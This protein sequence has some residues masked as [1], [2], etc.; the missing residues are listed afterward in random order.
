MKK[1]FNLARMFRLREKLFLA[2]K[3]FIGTQIV[4]QTLR[5]LFEDGLKALPP[6][7]ASDAFFESV[8]ALAGQ[9]LTRQLAL[10]FAGRIAGNVGMLINSLPVFPWTRQIRD[11]WVP[12][13][14][15]R[16]DPARRNNRDG[17]IFHCRALAG[18][19]C[20]MLFEQF[21]SRGSC[22]AIAHVV[23]FSR[24]MPYSTAQHFANLR[25]WVEVEAAKSAESPHF[26]QVD[27]TAAMK[28]YNKKLIGIRTRAVPC[29]RN[30]AH[31]CE[32]CELGYADCP[33]A[34][35]PLR[36]EKKLCPS[37]EQEAYF[38]PARNTAVCM[39]C[40]YAGAQKKIA[41]A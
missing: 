32:H 33:A 25:M 31:P 28:A 38:D 5:D 19:P 24:T 13:Q 29:P 26:Q 15:V 2:F 18:T 8:C 17:F 20:G 30:F 16:V 39:G 23:G 1:R 12:V 4:G 37:C 14:V 36:L 27:C 22:A 9:E 34:V 40:A 6:T 10:D 7:V 21:L 3:P 41:E 11:E 35:F